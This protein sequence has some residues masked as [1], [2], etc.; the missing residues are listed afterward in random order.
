MSK[1]GT[2]CHVSEMVSESEECRVAGAQLGRNSIDLILMD[3]EFKNWAFPPGC[4]YWSGGN[5]IYLNSASLNYTKD[6]HSLTGGIC[7]RGISDNV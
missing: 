2:E 3:D 4:F 6:I 5:Y 7:K 1:L